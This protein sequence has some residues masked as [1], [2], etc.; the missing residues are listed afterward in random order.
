MEM[1][2][3]ISCVGRAPSQC[4]FSRHR[5]APVGLSLQQVCARSAPQGQEQTTHCYPC[6]LGWHII[7]NQWHF[8]L[9]TSHFLLLSIIL[10][11]ERRK[12]TKGHGLKAT[13]LACIRK[14][15]PFQN[16]A[17]ALIRLVALGVQNKSCF[18]PNSNM[19]SQCKRTLSWRRK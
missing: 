16:M 5:S 11:G 15:K 19:K 4:P 1:E 8:S 7:I 13:K 17:P 3:G 9:N 6:L 14:I 2:G 10:L 12:L 18:Q